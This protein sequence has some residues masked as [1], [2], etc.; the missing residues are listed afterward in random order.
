[1]QETETNFVGR[2]EDVCPVL[3]LYFLIFQ[4]FLFSLLSGWCRMV[5]RKGA[6]PLTTSSNSNFSKMPAGQ[7]RCFWKVPGQLDCLFG[8]LGKE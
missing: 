1:M 5:S 3:R 7:N 2:A 6:C 8:V 4:I